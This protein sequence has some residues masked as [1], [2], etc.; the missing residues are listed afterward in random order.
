MTRANVARHQGDN[1][2]ARLFWLKATAFLDPKSNVIS[3]SYESGPK[4]FDDI[5][6]E[7]DPT[8]PPSD[9]EGRPIFRRHM[10]CKWHTTA[11]TFGHQDFIDPQFINAETNSLL[12]KVHTAQ[13]LYAADGAGAQFQFHTNWRLQADDP[14]LPIIRK[15]DGALDIAKLRIGGDRSAL[16]KNPEALARPSGN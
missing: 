13:N 14:L 5:S 1:F 16:G 9:R 8:R 12:R 10:Q 4:S 7:Y 15:D 2:Q 3:V 11:G 6:I